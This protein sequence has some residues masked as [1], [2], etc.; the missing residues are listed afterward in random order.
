MLGTTAVHNESSYNQMSP[1]TDWKHTTQFE[2][3]KAGLYCPK[4]HSDTK[5]KLRAGY[6]KE[7]PD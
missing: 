2:V 5:P 7:K 1:Y 3:G 4:C 6:R